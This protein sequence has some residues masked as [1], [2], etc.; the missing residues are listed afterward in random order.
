M[1]K[2][3]RLPYLDGLF[4]DEGCIQPAVNLHIHVLN[5]K[6]YVFGQVDDLL[7]LNVKVECLVS[8]ILLSITKA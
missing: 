8:A 2:I 7:P 3:E 1:K 6:G 5:R 4:V